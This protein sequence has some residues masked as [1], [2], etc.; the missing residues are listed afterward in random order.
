[1]ELHA[2]FRVVPIGW[3]RLL[4]SHSSAPLELGTDREAATIRPVAVYCSRS[5]REIIS[6]H[7]HNHAFVATESQKHKLETTLVGPPASN[8]IP[9]ESGVSSTIMC[10]KRP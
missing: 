2:E 5:G 6:S 8:R 3:L 9:P 7:S 10:G 1:M 4:Y